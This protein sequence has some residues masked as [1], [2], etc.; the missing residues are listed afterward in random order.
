MWIVTLNQ[1]PYKS[2]LL[3]YGDKR[4]ARNFIIVPKPRD[5]IS[6]T[7]SQLKCPFLMDSDSTMQKHFRNNAIIISGFNLYT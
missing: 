1:A 6:I 5:H 2:F 7:S 4:V 3:D